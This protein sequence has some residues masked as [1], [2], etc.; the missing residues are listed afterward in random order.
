LPKGATLRVELAVV[1]RIGVTLAR[2]Q[3]S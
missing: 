3:S 1:L 2:R